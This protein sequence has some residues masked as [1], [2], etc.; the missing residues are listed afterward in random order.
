MNL[1]DLSGWLEYFADGNNADFFAPAIED[2]Q[3]LIISTINI[4][5]VFKKILQQRNENDALQAMAVMQQGIIKPVDTSIA[6]FAA[7]L[8]YELK[9]PLADSIILATARLNSAQLWTQDSDFEGTEGV[10][11]INKK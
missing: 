9:I 11:Y 6:L 3:N 4:Y 2:V 8:S 7:R 5:E 10:K 1:V